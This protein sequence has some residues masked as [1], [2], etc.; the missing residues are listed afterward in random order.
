MFAEPKSA[1]RSK[2]TSLWLQGGDFT[3]AIKLG[4]MDTL[5]K[6]FTFYAHEKLWETIPYGRTYNLRQSKSE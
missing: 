5:V 3:L 4:P 6:T 2:R 1:N